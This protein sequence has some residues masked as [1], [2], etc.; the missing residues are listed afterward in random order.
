MSPLILVSQLCL[1]ALASLETVKTK[2]SE[3]RRHLSPQLLRCHSLDVAVNLEAVASGWKEFVIR[4]HNDGEVEV[5][6]F[7][8][9]LRVFHFP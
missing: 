8:V 7:S 3:N 6:L 9:F 5:R 2:V 1:K 4:W